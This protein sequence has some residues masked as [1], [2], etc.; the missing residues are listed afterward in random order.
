MM[1]SLTLDILEAQDKDDE[2]I[3]Y[4]GSRTHRPADCRHHKAKQMK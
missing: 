3:D 2:S 4:D 1:D